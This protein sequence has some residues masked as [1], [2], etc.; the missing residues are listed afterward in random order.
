MNK[1]KSFYNEPAIALLFSVALVTVG[2]TVSSRA[3]AEVKTLAP[4]MQVQIRNKEENNLAKKEGESY[5][6][7]MQVLEKYY[8]NLAIKAKQNGE[9][10]APLFAAADHFKVASK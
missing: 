8:R 7:Q 4:A 9:N 10:S 6:K 3:Y 2:A 5:K 1:N